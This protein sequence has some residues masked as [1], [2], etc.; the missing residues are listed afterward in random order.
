MKET[1][2]ADLTACPEEGEGFPEDLTARLPPEIRYAAIRWAGDHRA[3][4]EQ[5]RRLIE[6]V[7]PG[8][9]A[10]GSASLT[11]KDSPP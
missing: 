3:I 5:L 1:P 10:P 7:Q 8:A 6:W 9:C 4:A 2:P 11:I